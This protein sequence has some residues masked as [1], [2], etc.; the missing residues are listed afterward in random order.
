MV[1]FTYLYF[2]SGQFWNIPVSVEP[3]SG[4]ERGGTI[5]KNRLRVDLTTNNKP[6][7]FTGKLLPYNWASDQEPCLFV[8]NRQSGPIYAILDP[9]DGVIEG[10]FKDYKVKSAFSE[11]GYVFGLFD[12]DRCTEGSASGSH[13]Y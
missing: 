9:N 7:S 2:P 1:I 12:E 13:L 4:L 10:S 11:K 3:F 6:R 8:G 5:S